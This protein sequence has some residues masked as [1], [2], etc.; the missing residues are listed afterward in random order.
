MFAAI[1]RQALFAML[2]GWLGLTSA[3]A[4]TL[5]VGPGKTYTTIQSAIN[6]ASPGDTLEV[7]SGTYAEN[8]SWNK[9]VNIAEASGQTALL[10]GGPAGGTYISSS[11]A[12]ART[13]SGIDI[14]L[15]TDASI[16]RNT[17]ESVTLSN[18]LID[19]VGRGT[20]DAFTAFEG[21]GLILSNCQINLNFNIY[22]R[23][24]YLPP[25]AQG[26]LLLTDC[27]I[28][29]PGTMMNESAAGVIHLRRTRW[30]TTSGGTIEVFAIT[31]G[32]NF[33]FENSHVLGLSG[34]CL[35]LGVGTMSLTARATI[36]EFGRGGFNSPGA[37]GWVHSFQ[38]CVWLVSAAMPAPS[39]VFNPNSGSDG[40][41]TFDHS[42]FI[43]RGGNAPNAALVNNYNGYSVALTMRN[44]ILY[45]PG[46]AH[47]LVNGN[48]MTV[49]QNTDHN[50]RFG[51]DPQVVD[52][53]LEGAVVDANPL[54]A[55]DRIHLTENSPAIDAGAAI[56]VTSDIDGDDRP[57]GGAVDIGPDEVLASDVQIYTPTLGETHEGG[58]QINIQWS[59]RIQTAGTALRFELYR[60]GT[61]VDFI[62]SGW[63]PNGQG[64]S[65]VWLPL[66]PE[67][68]DYQI[69]ARSAWN[70]TL[71]AL[72]PTFAITGGPLRVLTPSGG[73]RF[74]PG[75]NTLVRWR[76]GVNFAGTA[77]RLELWDGPAE[78][79]G[80]GVDYDPRGE[81]VRWIQIPFVP[82]GHD[83]RIV[84][85]SLWDESYSASSQ[86]FTIG[87]PNA[88][89][90]ER[91]SVESQTWAIY[92]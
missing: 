23:L 67:A 75:V 78:S 61:F 11:G 92:D 31:T 10:S 76:S 80:L 25:G 85:V 16:C 21:T 36:F 69:L 40:T 32:S 63:N 13:W 91:T 38:N 66:V 27:E 60:A 2:L 51:Y 81:G 12:G 65:T 64:T 84:A 6:A 4:A 72:S 43:V 54:L 37:P 89:P 68:G 47:G 22:S 24:V 55:A 79:L 15:N 58:T 71:T 17:G 46:S 45:M 28:V 5:P 74:D 33:L 20:F 30:E 44:S 73:E 77:V 53:A 3:F 50:L 87:N 90:D 29:A 7:Y 88:T 39:V 9:A 34:N 19:D 57:Q 83:Y 26:E 48:A 41:L 35:G 62:G 1:I 70:V 56:G 82:G 42:S 86:P 52:D 49:T 8:L 59:T 18:I 14:R